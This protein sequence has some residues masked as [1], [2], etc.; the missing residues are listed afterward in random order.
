MKK[1]IEESVKKRV[2]G[3]ARKK[4]QLNK[5]K[6]GENGEEILDEQPL[7]HEVG[8][9][10]PPTMDEKIRA[11]TLQVQAETAA[12]LAAQNMSQEE[13][14]AVLDEENDFEVPEELDMTLTQYELTDT[15]DTLQE[16]AYLTTEPAVEQATETV[17]DAPQPTAEQTVTEPVTSAP[18]EQET[19]I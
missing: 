6:I 12:K 11:I 5:A 18:A 15:I 14:Q 4:V 1:S 13:V 9:K 16:D 10:K 19:V 7:F 17:Q 8:F 3:E 2:K